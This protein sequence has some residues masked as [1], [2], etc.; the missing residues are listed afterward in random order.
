MGVQAKAVLLIRLGNYR[1]LSIELCRFKGHLEP[2]SWEKSCQTFRIKQWSGNHLWTQ[3]F[4]SQCSLPSLWSTS[5]LHKR[6]AGKAAPHW[7]SPLLLSHVRSI[8]SVVRGGAWAGCRVST[9][10]LQP[11]SMLQIEHIGIYQCLQCAG[12]GIKRVTSWWHWGLI[13]L[14]AHIGSHYFI[15]RDLHSWPETILCQHC[16]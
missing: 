6:P 12:P 15:F 5:E 7:A 10:S 16:L 14:T 4:W 11:G 8:R 1:K 2:D 13:W 3:R 9:S